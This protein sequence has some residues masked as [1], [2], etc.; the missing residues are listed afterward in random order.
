MR[1]VLSVLVVVAGLLSSNEVSAQMIVAHRGASYD[2]PENTLAAFRLA[3][4][5]KADAIEGDFYLSGDNRIVCIH[6]R[7]TKRVAPGQPELSVAD[8]TLDELRQLDVGRW[9]NE[10]YA[11]EKIPTLVEVLATIPQG[12]QIFLEV[13]CGPEILN[14]LKHELEESRMKSNQVVIISF[15]REVI[16]QCRLMM[17]EYRANWLTSYKRHEND[18]VWKPTVDEVLNTLSRTEATGLGTNGNLHVVDRMFAERVRAAQLEL[19][20]W[21]VNSIEDASR[22]R[23]L[24]VD[25]ITTDRPGYILN[26]LQRQRQV[27]PNDPTGSPEDGTE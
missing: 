24:G 21:T 18:N 9:K 7:T 16:R 13:K 27:V 26:G 17:P 25:S 4:S 15:N 3:W 2:A 22:F 1:L 10:K 8:A 12:K 19:H 6:D 5:Q 20:V 23:S 11:G 14:V